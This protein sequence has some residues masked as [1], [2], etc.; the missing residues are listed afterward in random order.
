M[1]QVRVGVY[2][3]ARHGSTYDGLV[4]SKNLFQ[5]ADCQPPFR[6]TLTV[7]ERVDGDVVGSP[8]WKTEEVLNR[9][10]VVEAQ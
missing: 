9:D 10:D 8:I 4:G 7:V 5:L 1:Y 6:I 2:G 3:C